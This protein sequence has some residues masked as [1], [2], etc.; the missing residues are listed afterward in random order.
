MKAVVRQPVAGVLEEVLSIHA[1]PI[2]RCVSEPHNS[3]CR[4]AGVA[5]A[6]SCSGQGWRM[7]CRHSTTD[8]A[9]RAARAV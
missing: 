8:A 6:T 3:T 9:K 5:A 4:T 2:V 7:S 1:A